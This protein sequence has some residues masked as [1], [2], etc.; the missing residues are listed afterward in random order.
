[1]IGAHR[2]DDTPGRIRPG[3]NE[4]SAAVGV[5]GQLR[6]FRRLRYALPAPVP[7]RSAAVPRTAKSNGFAPALRSRPG[8]RRSGGGLAGGCSLNCLRRRRLCAYTGNKIDRRR[9][10]RRWRQRWRPGSR[11]VRWRRR[12]CCGG[13]VGV[14]VGV[15]GPVV[16]SG[17]GVFVGGT[18][19]LVGVSG[20]GVDVGCGV[21]VGA[22][23]TV[24][25][26]GPVVGEG[27]VFPWAPAE[28][29][30]LSPSESVCC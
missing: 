13:N 30:S 14:L 24:G 15:P 26:P 10:A 1:M 17:C 2:Q 18:G 27:L 12:S 20:P 6:R 23:V 5:A 22:G 3:I 25:V 4:S 28:L 16:G 21:L 19:V 29:G 11:R 8:A 7:S 9:R